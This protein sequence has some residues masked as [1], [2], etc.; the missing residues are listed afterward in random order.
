MDQAVNPFLKEDQELAKIREKWRSTP[1]LSRWFDLYFDPTNQQTFNKKTEAAI[2]AYGLDPN[3]HEDRKY[4][5]ELGSKNARKCK[6]FA[7][8]YLEQQ[9]WTKEKV[10]DLIASKAVT[11]NNAKYLLVLASL[12]DTYDEPLKIG[13]QNN[14][15]INNANVA[16]NNEIQ[17]SAEEEKQLS[18]D[19][20]E[21]VDNKYRGK[22]STINPEATSA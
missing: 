18:H 20:A 11:S 3:S 5:N 21:F 16:V 9:G 8:R 15:Q 19:F 1:R 17:L 4:A 2:V 10:L 14:V 6:D 7:R 12:T 22:P 13:Q